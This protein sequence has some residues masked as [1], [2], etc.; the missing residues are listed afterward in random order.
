MEQLQEHVAVVNYSD[1]YVPVFPKMRRYSFDLNSIEFSDINIP[2]YRCIVVAT[3]HDVFDYPII[4]EHAK[5]LVD[6]R[7]VNRSVH[8]N[9]VHL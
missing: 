5:L 7:G 4:L 1:M 9:V 2:S 6:A 8:K 3:N